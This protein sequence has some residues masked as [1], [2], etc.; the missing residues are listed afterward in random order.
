M[1]NALKAA[2]MVAA[3]AVCFVGRAGAQGVPVAGSVEVSG[4]L[5]KMMATGA[6]TTGWAIEMKNEQSFGGRPVKSIEVE[7][8]AKKFEKLE[9]KEVTATGTIVH[10]SGP[11]SKDRIVLQVEKIKQWKESKAERPSA[12]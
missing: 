11:E 1:N 10:R 3:M 5:V 8:K 6:E 12:Y 2:L 4:K 7:G 9:S